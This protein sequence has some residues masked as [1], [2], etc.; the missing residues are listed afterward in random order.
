MPKL[1]FQT[2]AVALLFLLSAEGFSPPTR[3]AFKAPTIALFSSPNDSEVSPEKLQEKASQYRE[4]AEKLRLN[5]ELKKIDQLSGEVRDFAKQTR[6]SMANGSGMSNDAVDGKKLDQL[7]GRVAD[8]VR[9]SSVIDENEADKMLGSLAS[10]SAKTVTAQTTSESKVTFTKEELEASVALIEAL[11]RA[12]QETLAITAG[13]FNY[14]ETKADPEAFLSKLSSHQVSN[15]ALRRV[16]A[17]SLVNDPSAKVVVVDESYSIEDVAD[18]LVEDLQDRIDGNRAMELFPRSIQDMDDEFLPQDEDAEAVFKLLDSSTFMSIQKPVRVNGGYVIRGVNKR[19]TPADLMEAIDKK[20]AAEI[21]NFTD[22]FQ[23]N[24]VEITADADSED[25]IEDSLLI[26][27]NKFPV[28]APLPLGLIATAISCFYG[29]TYAINTFAGNPVVM[30]RLKDANDA[31]TAL[32]SGTVGMDAVS[33]DLSWFNELLLPLL[34]SL[35]AIQGVHELGHLSVA[36]AN[37]IKLSAPVILPS[38]GLPYL[39]FQNRLKSSPKDYTALF[40]LAAAGPITGLSISFLAL[41]LG[42]QLTT[43]VDPETTQL[44]PSLSVGF[45]CQ[46]SLGGTL[47]DIV[48]GGGDGILINQEAAAQVPLHPIAIA[49]F[50]GM[51]INAL[52]LLPIGS[53]DGG[54][55]SQAALGR[56]WHLTFS[57]VVFFVIF[58]ATFVSDAQ[59]IFLGYLFLYSFTQRDLEIPCRNEVDKVE[60]PRVIVAVVSWAI[61]ALI[62]VPL[63]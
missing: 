15:M 31:A 28:K 51:L 25:F 19:S 22:S 37:K 8:L 18:A 14:N 20:I 54:R 3:R 12:A 42:L 48:L 55:M 58:V 30:Q 27:S 7:K 32:A 62:L 50:L 56:V 10:F 44:L 60:L 35:A 26:T 2:A 16:Y 53:T 47:V 40:D 9:S 34:G 21:P 4:E 63:R 36:W 11:P 61:A 29:F 39:S 1:R 38:Q 43:V 59:D 49:G 6:E 33:Y 13:Y 52:D 45:L 46:S 57:S 41:L 17:Q 23:V 24:Y 5:L